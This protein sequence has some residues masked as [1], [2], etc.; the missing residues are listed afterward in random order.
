MPAVMVAQSVGSSPRV[1]QSED[2]NEHAAYRT[3]N[4]QRYKI[5]RVFWSSVIK[6]QASKPMGVATDIWLSTSFLKGQKMFHAIYVLP[7][8]LGRN[9]HIQ[10]TRPMQLVPRWI[11]VLSISS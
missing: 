5:N 2:L 10:K 7:M 9:C 8:H 1:L 4:N 3:R 6:E 11:I